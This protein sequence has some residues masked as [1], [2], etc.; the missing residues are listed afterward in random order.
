MFEGHWRYIKYHLHKQNLICF[1]K[2]IPDYMQY[3]L[4]VPQWEV[5]GFPSEHECLLLFC[6]V[7]KGF[8]PVTIELL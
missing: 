4:E 3:C 7:E 2:S 8:N 6:A 1:P 5:A